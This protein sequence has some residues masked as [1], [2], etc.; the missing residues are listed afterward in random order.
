M[1]LLP[2]AHFGDVKNEAIDWRQRLASEPDGDEQ[3]DQ[4]ASDDVIG[5]L[6]FDPDEKESES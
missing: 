2:K 5:M 3:D 1:P 6:G 4:P